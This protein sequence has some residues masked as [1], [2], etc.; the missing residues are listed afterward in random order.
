MKKVFAAVA[1]MAAAF[2]LAVS[3][4]QQ[5]KTDGVV[6]IEVEPSE[7]TLY[8]GMSYQ[9]EAYVT[10]EGETVVWSS[11]NESVATVGQDG[12]VTA[13]SAGTA[14]V[15]AAAGDKSAVCAV[16]VEE[17]YVDMTITV[18]PGNAV[19]EVG[20]TLALTA[21]VTPEND[22]NLPVI[23]SSSDDGIAAVDDKGTVTGISAGE[24]VIT[25]TVGSVSDIC[26]VTVEEN[27]GM[28]QEE[29]EIGDYYYSDG[30]WSSDLADGKD[31]IG[32]V[33]WKG[34]PTEDDPA[35]AAD[36]KDCTHGLVV[37]VSGETYTPWQSAYASCGSLVN[38][39]I[40]ANTGYLPIATY[41]S[42]EDNINKKLGYNNTKA[43]EEFNA[44]PANASWPVEAVQ[45]IV[46]Y[47]S[48]VPAPA[49]SSDWYM[50]SPR[51]LACLIYKD[52]D[53]V[54]YDVNGD[55][56]MR[57]VNDRL[58]GVGGAEL[59]ASGDLMF[60]ASSAEY[61]MEGDPDAGQKI[62][63]LAAGSNLD[64]PVVGPCSK[65]SPLTVVRPI[66]AF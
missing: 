45:A 49:A 47:R 36:F 35:L 48:E 42:P 27:G 11:D 13:V 57:L 55:D 33:F 8:E 65:S 53:D 62:W 52:V 23:W 19:I 2:V 64:V 3:C 50:P 9:L 61:Y 15:T 6:S 14:S 59:L 38:D 18:E 34:D 28:V 12:T 51:E 7:I 29:P 21:T 16:T 5:Q 30:T 22:L 43:I 1:A 4:E 37:A 54:Y 66:L 31:V 17:G 26:N 58:A 24:A 63:A 39:W 20:E 10:P 46:D 32:I 40:T 60:Y 25:A 56:N 44:A 41:L